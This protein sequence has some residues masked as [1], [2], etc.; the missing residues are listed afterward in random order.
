MR[1]GQKEEPPARPEKETE[2][3]RAGAAG[4]R[5]RIRRSQTDIRN[6]FAS[7]QPVVLCRDEP[8]EPGWEK[9]SVVMRRIRTWLVN[10]SKELRGGTRRFPSSLPLSRTLPSLVR[11]TRTLSVVA[12]DRPLSSSKIKFSDFCN[13]NAPLPVSSSRCRTIYDD[14]NRKMYFFFF[15]RNIFSRGINF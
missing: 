14:R 1:T 4:A 12:S 6:A 13:F 11:H 2:R 9:A 5:K 15:K 8:D 7:Y 10:L 3:W